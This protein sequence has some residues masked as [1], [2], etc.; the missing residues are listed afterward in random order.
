ML[1]GCATAE[2]TAAFGQTRTQADPGHWRD[3]LGLTVSSIGFGSYLGNPDDATDKEYA[4][5]L[6][7][8]MSLGVNLIDSAI[9]YRYQRSERAIGAALKAAVEADEISREHVVVCTKGGYLPAEEPGEWFAKEV[10]AK[11]LAAAE[12]LVD[13]CHCLA[14]A[15]LKD[16][17][18]RSRANLGVEMIDV[19]YVHNPEQQLPTLGPDAF[20]ARL[21]E[22]FRAL[23]TAAE[24]GAIAC[25]GTATWDGFRVSP[26]A[27]NHVSLERLLQC[28]AEAGGEEHHFRVVQLPFNLGLVEAA[29]APTQE[30]NGDR[31]TLLDAA[32]ECGVI[33]ITSAPLLQGRLIGRMVPQLR[34]R[35]PG[36]ETDAQRLLQFA[37]SAPGVL[38]PLVG[39]KSAA[40]VEENLRLIAKP[41]LDDTGWSKLF[42]A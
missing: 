13:D 42:Q 21:T 37:R 22:A 38:A 36:L 15:F 28:A 39:M 19:Y 17:I 32:Y 34:E 24:E 9:N 25:Y 31:T 8:A 6:R 23:E 16:Q 33:V 29:A 35:F 5:A 11:K 20:Y 4:A 18:D 3:A 14:P 1:P 10:V 41:P 27:P 2:G 7:K 12:D 26:G 30:L 40:H